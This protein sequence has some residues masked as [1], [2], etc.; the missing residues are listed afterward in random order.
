MWRRMVHSHLSIIQ[1]ILFSARMLELI[2][3]VTLTGFN[4]PS[5]FS[6]WEIFSIKNGV[7]FIQ[8][9]GLPESTS[10]IFRSSS[11]KVMKLMAL[12]QNSLIV[13][14]IKP[15]RIFSKSGV[16]LRGGGCVLGSD[17]YWDK[18]I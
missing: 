3:V 18:K 2:S 16:L 5:I 8:F 17:T 7:L 10:I 15:E 12:L 1:L 4:S 13:K 11:L 9:Q 14:V 6:I